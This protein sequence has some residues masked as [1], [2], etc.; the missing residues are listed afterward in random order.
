[1]KLD[2][3]ILIGA[4]KYPTY[5]VREF[6]SP[7]GSSTGESGHPFVQRGQRENIACL[8]DAAA[9]QSDKTYNSALQSNAPASFLSQAEPH[10]WV[11][12]RPA[13]FSDEGRLMAAILLTHILDHRRM[14][15]ANL[16]IEPSSTIPS[17]Q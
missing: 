17:F 2:Q 13:E 16:K 14:C 3:S 11:V 4:A 7:G 9:P 5:C 8:L 1:M 15:N 6:D 10:R 12:D